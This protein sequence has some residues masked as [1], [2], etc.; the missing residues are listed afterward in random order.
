MGIGEGLELMLK[1]PFNSSSL[2]L[3]YLY[4]YATIQK[5]QLKKKGDQ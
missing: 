5:T 1:L 3:I 4:D 2:E